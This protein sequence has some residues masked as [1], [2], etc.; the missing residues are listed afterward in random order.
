MRVIQGIQLLVQNRI[1]SRVL[2]STESPKPPLAVRLLDWIPPLQRI[3]ARIVG[4]GVQ[5]EHVHTPDAGA[6]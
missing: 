4:L 3:P 5:R 6:R 1:I 2:A